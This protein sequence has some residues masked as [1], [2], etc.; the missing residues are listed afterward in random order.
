MTQQHDFKFEVKRSHRRRTLSLQIRDGQVQVMVPARTPDRQIQDLLSKHGAWVRRKLREQAARPKAAAKAFVAGEPFTYLGH[1]YPLRIVD[2]APWP[3]ELRSDEIVV[4]VPE[5]I[6][7]AARCGEV[8]GRLRE[9][10]LLNALEIFQD[11]AAYFGAQLGLS[12]TSVRVKS[13]KRRWGSCSARGELS[14]NWRLIMAP[15]AV[16][17]YVAAHEVSHLAH[18]NHSA[19]FWAVVA[20]LMP[21]YSDQQAWLNRNGGTLNI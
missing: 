15:G 4:T 19:A 14:F 21:D 12:A 13:Y 3:A 8:Q 1:D 17:D 5:R 11:R 9:W 18:H 16:V 10:Y 6:Q 2:G 7:G 20:G